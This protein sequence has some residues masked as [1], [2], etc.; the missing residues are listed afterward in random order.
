VILPDEFRFVAAAGLFL[1]GVFFYWF[2]LMMAGDH[3][4]SAY[5]HRWSSGRLR[6]ERIGTHCYSALLGA[7]LPWW[8]GLQFALG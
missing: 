5:V 1:V 4:T 2:L 6:V 7:G 8:L 3:E